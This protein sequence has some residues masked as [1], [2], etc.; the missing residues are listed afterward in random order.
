MKVSN[1]TL[2]DLQGWCGSLLPHVKFVHALLNASRAEEVPLLWE[3]AWICDVFRFSIFTFL[4]WDFCIFENTY[5]PASAK[6]VILEDL[7]TYNATTNLQIASKSSMKCSW[8]YLK[9]AFKTLLLAWRKCFVYASFDLIVNF[10]TQPVSA[11]NPAK[12]FAFSSSRLQAIK[13]ISISSLVNQFRYID[14]QL[15]GANRKQVWQT[16]PH[17]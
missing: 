14:L 2:V 6:S 10:S 1:H 4:L 11:W 13:V 9:N 3:L 15:A 12:A 17:R 5:H 8:G 16:N 7:G